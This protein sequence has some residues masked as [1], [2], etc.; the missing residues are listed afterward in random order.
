MPNPA[1]AGFGKAAQPLDVVADPPSLGND[2]GT[3]RFG[4]LTQGIERASAVALR[5]MAGLESRLDK[6]SYRPNPPLPLPGGDLS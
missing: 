6:T 3:S 1:M 5:A 2:G 4:G